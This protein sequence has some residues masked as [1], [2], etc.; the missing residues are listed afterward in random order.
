MG[1]A[2]GLRERKRVAQHQKIVDTSLRLFGQHGYTATTVDQICEAA[3]I[4]KA[5][6]FRYF[7]TKASV[8]EELSDAVYSSLEAQLKE[9]SNGE[10]SAGARLQHF[11]ELVRGAAAADLGLTRAMVDS[12]AMD[13][14]TN[15][16]VSARHTRSISIL[17]EI[18]RS[19]QVTGELTAA[20][21]AN[22]LAVMI[23]AMA[24]NTV[25]TWAQS[26]TPNPTGPDMRAIVDIFL[27]G[28]SSP[29]R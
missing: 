24:F 27:H 10:D 26:A 13:P 17:A 11:Y 7:P 20:I 21:D 25:A 29:R 6:F 28:A 3:E 5:T 2:V 1:M 16:V 15:P 4:G 22:H 8:L 18:L 14:I 9:F 23:E 12:G 19:G